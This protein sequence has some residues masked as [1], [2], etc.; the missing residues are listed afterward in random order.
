MLPS[1]PLIARACSL[2]IVLGAVVGV[3]VAQPPSAAR[4]A[5]L[6]TGLDSLQAQVDQLAQSP[7]LQSRD[8]KARLADVAVFAK[9]LE[10]MLRYKEFP[11]KNSADQAADAIRIGQQRAVNLA[12]GNAPWEG[13]P[14]A[15]VCG[16]FSRIDGSVQPC[17]LTLPA[18]V[19]PLSGVRW[20]LHVKLHGRA[21][22]M[23]EVSFI[24]MHEGRP[25][26]ADQNWI[27]LDVYGRG[28]NAYRWA[29]ETDVLEAIADVRRRFRIDDNRI[30]VRGFSMGGA[31]AWHL[32]LHYPAMWSSVGPGAGFVDFYK[33]QKQTQQLPAWQH[34]T[35]GI[36]DA[37]DYAL[38]AANV[39]VCT[40]GG[41]NDA[42][43]IA[44][45]SMQ[46]AARDLGV[47]IRLLVGPG[48]GHKFHPDSYKEYMAFHLEKS[49]AG[50]PRGLRR[51]QVRFTTR[52]L[53][54]NRCDWL[55]IEEVEQVYAPST[56]EATL[57]SDGNVEI[58]TQNIA[59]LSVA[60]DAGSFAI[61]D[62]DF[63]PCYDA[64]EGLLPTVYYEKASDGWA[65]L[66]YEDSRSFQDNPDVNKRHGLQGPIDDAF[67]E[68]FVLVK[69]TGRTSRASHQQWSDWTRERFAQ[70]FDKWMRAKVRSVDDTNLTDEQI[71]GSHLVLFGDPS[72]NSVIRK[73]LS[74]LPV[75]W[76]DDTFSVG[77]RSFSTKDHGL[78]MI[79]PNPLNSR[80]YVVL[81][82]GHTYHEPDFKASNSWLFPRL[83][84]IAVQRFVRQDDGSYREEI[85]WAANFNAGWLLPAEE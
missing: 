33:Y 73:V 16:Y 67:M 11:K 71:R 36:Y 28:N 25:L 42:Q 6:Q 54:Y 69:A 24:A 58:T 8:G 50:R 34:A 31:G 15:S 51:K 64:A 32:G 59:V 76:N 35:L 12:A 57:K 52:T 17:A 4:L 62:G 23:N 44:S 72:S 46:Q 41:E 63:L 84:D 2:L 78:S 22:N 60:R 83:G 18:G 82:S 47:D 75:T 38:N 53:K 80:R 40:Y 43:L 55:T 49:Q 21:N 26:P 14:G 56:V 65:A 1:R 85:V 9:A 66:T 37:I 20:P 10:W 74:K 7:D 77:G 39:P 48:M 81:N 29:G 70:E 30:T 13:R 5:E 27:Q 68:S 79:Y 19:D 61:I 3:V 45:T